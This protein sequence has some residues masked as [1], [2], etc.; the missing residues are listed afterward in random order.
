MHRQYDRRYFG[1]LGK[2]KRFLWPCARAAGSSSFLQALPR[3]D[4][5]E[6]GSDLDAFDD[7]ETEY[8][9]FGP[10]FTR[11]TPLDSES[12]SSSDSAVVYTEFRHIV[13]TPDV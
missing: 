4:D 13:D 7:T 10:E 3:H 5:S 2:I 1:S 8:D 12:E 6:L 11:T 9:S